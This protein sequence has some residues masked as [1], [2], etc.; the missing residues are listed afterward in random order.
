MVG[1]RGHSLP[2]AVLLVHMIVVGHIAVA[3]VGTEL[4]EVVVRRQVARVA[5]NQRP[6]G[7]QRLAQQVLPADK[8]DFVRLDPFVLFLPHPTRGLYRLSIT[9]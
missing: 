2:A 8:A 1:L 9:E 3:V 7:A 6:R 4:V 5:Q